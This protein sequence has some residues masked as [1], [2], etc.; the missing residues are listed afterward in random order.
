MKL[1]RKERIVAKICEIGA[2]C[3]AVIIV[4]GVIIAF[5]MVIKN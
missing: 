1:R 5:V 2:I 4:I 3:I